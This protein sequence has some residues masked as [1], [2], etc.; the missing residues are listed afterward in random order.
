MSPSPP[1]SFL[2]SLSPSQRWPARLPPPSVMGHCRAVTLNGA[3]AWVTVAHLDMS[4][5]SLLSWPALPMAPGAACCHSAYVSAHTS[6]Y[7][8]H[9]HLTQPSACCLLLFLI[10][11][12]LQL[13]AKI[14][15]CPWDTPRME[16][17]VNIVSTA[18]YT[19]IGL[20]MAACVFGCVQPSFAVTQ[21]LQSV[22][23]E[24]DEVSSINQRC[25]S[26]A[27][28]LLFWS[29]RQPGFVK[30]TVTGVGHSHAVSVI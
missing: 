9:V 11:H 18:L 5:H 14:K 28:H 22:V 10:K 25:P 3:A 21:V 30:V 1:P 15:S 16:V 20:Y 23:S 13:E 24:R 4:S 26:H 29:A 7:A 6:T 19:Q 2:T 17:L 12:Q 8:A 27:L